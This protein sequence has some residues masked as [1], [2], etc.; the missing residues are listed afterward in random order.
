MSQPYSVGPVICCSSTRSPPL[1]PWF[2]RW[3]VHDVL[4]GLWVSRDKINIDLLENYLATATK[5]AVLGKFR[6]KER[7]RRF[8][9]SL[10]QTQVIELPIEDELHC[11]KI[12]EVIKNEVEHLPERCRLIFKCSR[13]EGKPVKQIARELKLSPKT[14]EN[15]LTKAIK[16][17]RLATKSLLHSF[18][19]FLL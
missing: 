19:S 7:E 2:L 13:E 11:K 18:F 1:S 3:I 9:N 14:V 8:Q 15:Q 17:L 10:Q 5:Y 16:Q 6:K 12:L 4:V